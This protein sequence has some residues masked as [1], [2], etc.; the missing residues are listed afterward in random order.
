MPVA[1]LTEL[2]EALDKIGTMFRSALDDLGRVRVQLLEVQRENVMLRADLAAVPPIV[3]APPYHEVS[4]F[5]GFGRGVSGGGGKPVY[6]VTTLS[7]GGPGSLREALAKGDRTIEFTVAGTILLMRELRL[8]APNVTIDGM[9]APAPGIT[10]KGACLS[11]RTQNV[12]VQGIRHRGAPAG[13]DGIAVYG[14]HGVVLDHVSVS[15]F[16]D[17]GIDITEGSRDVTMQW[18]I[19]GPGSAAGHNFQ[20]LIKYDARRVT[21]HHNLFYN[22]DDRHPFVGFSD[23]ANATNEGDVVADVRNNLVWGWRWYGTPVRQ[24]GTANVIANYYH[25]TRSTGRGPEHVIYQAEGGVAYTQGNVSAQHGTTINDGNGAAAYPAE[26]VQ[27]TDALGAARLVVA[28]AGARGPNFGL[29]AVDAGYLKGI[30][31][32]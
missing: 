10:L 31:L 23:D 18:C 20:S 3:V 5:E 17:G 6:R 28:G 14:A 30:A 11:I 26:H 32:P 7:D 2:S 8:L 4:T 1:T 15:G 27:T 19:L 29:D 24:H 22:G 9:N 13:I 12:I 25:S 16:G 21:V